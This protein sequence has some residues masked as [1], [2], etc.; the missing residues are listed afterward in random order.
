MTWGTKSEIVI[1]SIETFF[2]PETIPIAHD[3][4]FTFDFIKSLYLR[5]IDF[6]LF[7][8]FICS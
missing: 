3:N 4:I 6:M 8:M 5:A 7:I 1:F 2:F